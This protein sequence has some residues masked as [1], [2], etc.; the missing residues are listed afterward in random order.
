LIES[1][2]KRKA[3]VKDS[4]NLLP[5]HGGFFDRFDALIPASCAMYVYLILIQEFGYVS[6]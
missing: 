2:I 3:E 6:L 4:S 5:G 1:K